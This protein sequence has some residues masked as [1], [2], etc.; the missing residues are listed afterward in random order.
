MPLFSRILLY[1]AASGFLLSAAVHGAAI[2]RVEADA[3]P[4]SPFLLHLFALVTFGAAVIQNSLRMR[5]MHPRHRTNSFLNILKQRPPWLLAMVLILVVYGSVNFLLFASASTLRAFSS[6]WLLFFAAA[7]FVAYP[8]VPLP[9]EPPADGA[10][11]DSFH[12]QFVS[13]WDRTMQGPVKFMYIW[14]AILSGG[15]GILGFYEPGFLFLCLFFGFGLALN[16]F[17]RMRSTRILIS[18]AVV[19]GGFFSG[20]LYRYNTK[21]RFHYPLS[22]LKVE[23]IEENIRG[24]SIFSLKLS[25]LKGREL[26]RQYLSKEWHYDLLKQLHDRLAADVSQKKNP[27]GSAETGG[28]EPGWPG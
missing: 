21:E 9:D 4:V 6:G 2:Y 7:F 20:E 19:S 22:D 15:F 24:N 26:L 8:G 13:L 16:L 12:V 28:Q 27:P 10:L 3:Y 1:V 17:M 11:P 23:L 5:A 14:L 25:D 18:N